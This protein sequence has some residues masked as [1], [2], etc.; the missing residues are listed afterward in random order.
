MSR[1]WRVILAVPG[2][3]VILAVLAWG[4]TG[5]PG[6]GTR[7]GVYGRFIDHVAQPERHVTNYVSAVM[8]DY[9]GVDTMIEEF[10]LFTS[11]SS[12]RTTW[13]PAT[14]SARWAAGSRRSCCCSACG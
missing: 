9:R 11:L 4:Y 3:A 8:F 2:L 5:L 12:A 14:R 10:I 1:R 6:F 7:I 13:S